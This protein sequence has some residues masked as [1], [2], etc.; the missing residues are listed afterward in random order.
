VEIWYLRGPDDGK[1]HLTLFP[2]YF[3]IVVT[4][5]RR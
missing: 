4:L 1:N 2:L 3:I 5:E